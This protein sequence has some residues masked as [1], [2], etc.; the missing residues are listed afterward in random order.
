MLAQ[1]EEKSF[2]L[3]LNFKTPKCQKNMRFAKKIECGDISL[4]GNP[5]SVSLVNV[6]GFI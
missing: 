4:N 5:G 1:Q 2:P 3:S 6:G